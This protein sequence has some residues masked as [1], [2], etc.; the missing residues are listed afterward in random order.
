MAYK[1]ISELIAAKKG[2]RGSSIFY[3]K[4]AARNK[5]RALMTRAN[6]ECI[7]ILNVTDSRGDPLGSGIFHF[8]RRVALAAAQFDYV[9]ELGWRTMGGNTLVPFGLIGTNGGDRPA[10]AEYP[11]AKIPPGWV[12]GTGVGVT[13]IGF[14]TVNQGDGYTLMPNNDCAG[15][16]ASPPTKELFPRA[17]LVDVE[18][19]CLT[20]QLTPAANLISTVHASDVNGVSFNDAA[21]LGSVTIPCADLNAPVGGAIVKKRTGIS[22]G[23]SRNVTSRLRSDVTAT[24]SVVA[25]RRW[26]SQATPHGLAVTQWGRGGQPLAT[27]IMTSN[28]C[29]A[30][31]GAMP[32]HHIC[33]FSADVNDF[34]TNTAVQFEANVRAAMALLRSQFG[35]DLFFIFEH[36]S[37]CYISTAP[38]R[39][40]WDQCAGVFAAICDSDSN[41]C[42]VI[43]RAH[44][45]RTGYGVAQQQKTGLVDKGAWSAASVT[46]DAGDMV[47]HGSGVNSLGLEMGRV[48]K[49][50]FGH[51]SAAGTAP[52]P[53]SLGSQA[54]W[55]TMDFFNDDITPS[56]DDVHHTEKGSGRIAD[57]HWNALMSALGPSGGGSDFIWWD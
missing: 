19:L 22:F 48:H 6:T 17:S 51:V 4:S 25:G 18:Y 35:G 33:M 57:I 12:H 15:I 34:G 16:Y 32:K 14:G 42:L 13:R 43:T 7:R 50:K 1:L 37:D 53:A 52:T 21:S 3:G 11:Q 2:G 5:G 10:D 30:I 36:M 38:I 56:L 40:E 24:H 8:N 23:A 55:L 28:D 46:Y 26:V 44:L 54:N 27:N 45:D 9:T 20:S 31:I 29:G 41:C 39:T 49:A 47:Q